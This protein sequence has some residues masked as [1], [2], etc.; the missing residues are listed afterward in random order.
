M[1]ERP[2][3]PRGP[4]ASCTARRAAHDAGTIHRPADRPRPVGPCDRLVFTDAAGIAVVATPENTA[5]R[6]PRMVAG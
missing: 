2:R 4:D 3:A 6:T 5:G 1:I